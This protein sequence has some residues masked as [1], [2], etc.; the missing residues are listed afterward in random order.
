MPIND[1]VTDDS[2]FEVAD[3]APKAPVE[4]PEREASPAPAERKPEVEDIDV[5]EPAAKPEEKPEAKP[6]GKAKRSLEGRKQTIQEQINELVRE[7]G[8][9]QRERDAIAAELATLRTE[10]DAIQAEIRTGK[11]RESAKPGERQDPRE[12]AR[13]GEQDPAW[14]RTSRTDREPQESEFDDFGDYVRAQSNWAAREAHRVANFRQREAGQRQG[15]ERHEQTRQ[16]AFAGRYSE[17]AKTNPTFEAEVNREDLNLTAPMIDVIKDSEVGP[18]LM[19]FLARNPEE[20]DRLSAMHPVLAYGEMKKFEARQE[21][22]HSGPALNAKPVS[23]A[24]ALIKP[25]DSAGAA[26][27]DGEL[28]E[29]LDMDEFIE[30]GNALERRRRQSGQ[31]A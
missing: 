10:R 18:Q 1:L 28:P 17:F 8:T 27:D 14:G 25:V 3:N 7:K 23:K 12:G 15:R 26:G 4:A 5:D 11:P 22:A 30:R 24:H 6:E 20:V 29:D 31:R 2:D 19:L 9:T 21:A 16:A 13:A